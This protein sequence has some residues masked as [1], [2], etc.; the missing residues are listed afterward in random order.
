LPV[1]QCQFEFAQ[2]TD[3]RGRVQAKV[4]HGLL[5][6]TLDVPDTDLLLAWAH[7]AHKPLGGHVTFFEPDQRTARETLSF[8]AGQCV[9]YHETF[10]AGN[11]EAGAAETLAFQPIPAS[12]WPAKHYPWQRH[13]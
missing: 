7:T 13:P 3:P 6:L 8:A 5:H 12:G 11:G 10:V 4:R 1:R 2:A 9:S